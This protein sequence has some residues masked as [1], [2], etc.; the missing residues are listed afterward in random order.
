LI[1]ILDMPRFGGGGR[2]TIDIVKQYWK[3]NMRDPDLLLEYAMRYKRGA[4]FKRLGFLAEK[5]R[6]PISEKWLGI[7]HNHIS[8]GISNLDPDSPKTG[9]IISKWNLRINLPI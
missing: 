9:Q 6:V 4:V 8:K 7:C 1:D 3:S 5:L 2:H